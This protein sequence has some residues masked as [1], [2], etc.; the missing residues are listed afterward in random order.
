MLL[1]LGDILLPGLV[2]KYCRRF[3]ALKLKLDKK[4]PGLR[5]KK[6]KMDFYLYNLILYFISVAL[7]MIMMFVFN[8][9]QPVL[10][11]IS[12]IFILGLMGKAYNDGCFGIFWNGINLK[13]KINNEKEKKEENEES[14]EENE[15]E[16]DEEDN[17]KSNGDKNKRKKFMG[18]KYEL[19]ELQQLNLN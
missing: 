15:E 14:E 12:P 8:H 10:F 17:N 9:G 7:A 18:K 5:K 16:E 19:N 11:Y 6:N 2:I 3:D 1:G 4:K 13:K